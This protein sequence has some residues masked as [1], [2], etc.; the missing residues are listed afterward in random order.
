MIKKLPMSLFLLI[1]GCLKV[2]PQSGGVDLSVLEG[3][4][5]EKYSSLKATVK[6]LQ[7]VTLEKSRFASGSWLGQER[8]SLMH[9]H[10]FSVTG[11][12]ENGRPAYTYKQFC[13][14]TDRK[15]CI[16]YGNAFEY[17]ENGNMRRE[18]GYNLTG[19][20][21]G[22]YI[23]YKEDGTMRK[24]LYFQ[25]GSILYENQRI[26]DI[27][28]DEKIDLSGIMK[29]E[30]ELRRNKDKLPTKNT[31]V[32][33][34][35]YNINPQ[36]IPGYVGGYYYVTFTENSVMEVSP[37]ERVLKAGETLYYNWRYA[38]QTADTGILEQF[39]WGEDKI[40]FR[41]KIKWLGKDSFEYA[42][43]FSDNPDQIDAKGVLN[44]Q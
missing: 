24:R 13:T 32:G 18:G 22:L 9:G 4:I 14:D 1:L 42:V 8:I 10:F 2:F 21:H 23:S 5:G 39:V 41:V 28:L 35:R 31:L 40:I 34:W 3:E 30:N 6:Y 7:P 37:T 12:F 44:R 11:Y 33:K 17:Y 36:N 25:N 20:P 15:E 27:P 26:K 16:R 19:R 43:I 29:V 38:P